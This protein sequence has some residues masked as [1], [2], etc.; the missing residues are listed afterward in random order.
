MA[1]Y[2]ERYVVVGSAPE[3][4]MAAGFKQVGAD[5]PVFLHPE[6][7]EEYALA[8]T[9]RKAGRGYGGFICDFSPDV[10]LEEDLS[11]RDLAINAMALDEAGCLIDPFGG[12]ADLERR[13]LR[14]V[15]DAFRE[16]PVRVLRVARFMARHAHEGWSVAH[17]PEIDTG[18]HTLLVLD[19]ATG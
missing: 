10:T 7:D 11:R 4:L 2:H 8:R 1:R 12:K 17:H 16:D 13:V 19:Q 14:H 5:F 6:T 15:S 18:L 9:E 3:A